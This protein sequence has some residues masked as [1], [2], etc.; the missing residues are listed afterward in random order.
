MTYADSQWQSKCEI[1]RCTHCIVDCSGRRLCDTCTVQSFCY[2]CVSRAVRVAQ[3]RQAL[4]SEQI[5][6][7]LA[8]FATSALEVEQAVDTD[9]SRRASRSSSIAGAGCK[10]KKGAFVVKCTD[11]MHVRYDNFPPKK[12]NPRI[13]TCHNLRE[14]DPPILQHDAAAGSDRSGKG[15]LEE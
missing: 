5:K 11:T 1:R 7:V 6:S 14:G 12:T 10:E 3:A 8:L 13:V 2:K 4:V 15:T 9:A